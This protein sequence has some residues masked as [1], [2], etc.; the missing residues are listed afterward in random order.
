MAGLSATLT[1]NYYA[2]AAIAK[3]RIVKFGAADNQVIL[4]AGSAVTEFLIGVATEIDAAT[5][6]PIDVI[7]AGIADVEY[8]GTVTRGQPLTSDATGRAIAA[9]PGAGVNFRTIG[10]AE[11]SAVIGDV[12]PAQIIPGIMQG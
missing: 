11:V 3:R 1:K 10:F 2:G 12:G 7:R 6:E 9:A 8:G 5:G 4:G